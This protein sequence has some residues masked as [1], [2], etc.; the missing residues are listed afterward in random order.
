V[1][2]TLLDFN[3]IRLL[4]QG[5]VLY[6]LDSGQHADPPAGESSTGKHAL[7]IAIQPGALDG[8]KQLIPDKFWDLPYIDLASEGGGNKE[9]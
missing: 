6:R 2:K 8:L 3:D 7:E 9:A 5:K 4:F 1:I